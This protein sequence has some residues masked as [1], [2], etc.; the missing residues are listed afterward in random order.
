MRIEILW[1][2]GIA[3][4]LCAPAWA[5]GMRVLQDRQEAQLEQ[6]EADTLQTAQHL[7]E[8]AFTAQFLNAF[9]P[10]SRGVVSAPLSPAVEDPSFLVVEEPV[11]TPR[12]AVEPLPLESES[13]DAVGG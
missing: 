5:E 9:E 1:I 10:G 6:L 8:E 4:L 11:R 13:W 2:M 3:A 7:V 12:K